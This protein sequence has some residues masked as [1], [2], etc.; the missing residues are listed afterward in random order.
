MVYSG[1]TGTVRPTNSIPLPRYQCCAL[2]GTGKSVLRYLASPILISLCDTLS[3]SSSV[4]EKLQIDSVLGSL[5]V[6]FYFDFKDER[7]Q[8]LSGALSSLVFQLANRSHACFDILTAA[9]ARAQKTSGR[10]VHKSHTD[11][12]LHP[13][14]DILL[15][16]LE[17]MLH[18][19]SKTFMILDAFDEC[20]EIT[21]ETD[22]LP[23]LLNLVGLNIAGLRLLVTSRPERDILQCLKSISTHP[24][25]LNK[26]HEKNGELS[27]Y[28]SHELSSPIHYKSWPHNVKLQA[29][30]ILVEKARGM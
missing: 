4:I 24:L 12:H 22:A 7:K 18:A 10:M 9:Y 14:D 30:K 13:T 8:S 20:P 29:E 23:F 21:R 11:A 19:T 26:A 28:I 1:C 5:V 2:A 17:L 3:H 25:D 15:E 27:R 6:Y 16:C